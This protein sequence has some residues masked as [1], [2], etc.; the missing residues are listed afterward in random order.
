MPDPTSNPKVDPDLLTSPQTYRVKG[1]KS[2]LVYPDPRLTAEDCEV[3]R[4]M[5][6]T[7]RQ[8]ARKRNGFTLYN[9]TVM[10]SSVAVTG[11]YQLPFK[12]A[13]RQLEMAGT[14]IYADDGTTRTD[15]TD[16]AQTN[17]AEARYRVAFLQ[18]KAICTNGVN[19]PV[20]WDGTVGATEAN[21]L[22]APF[23][24]C[25]DFIVHQNVL[26]ALATTE[27]G[28]KHT[29]RARWCDVDGQ[30]LTVDVTNWP[31]N[32]R[33][34][35]YHDG[36][37]I[38]GG[39]D[40]NGRLLVFKQD[41]MY[42]SVIRV[43]ND[44]Q[45]GQFELF[46]LK[47]SIRRNFEPIAKHSI[48][49]TPEFAWCVARDGAYVIDNA[50]NMRN[51]IVPGIEADW[52]DLNQGRLQ[53][54]VSWIRERDHQVRTLLSSSTNTSG[55]DRVLVWD[56]DTDDVWFD[57]PGQT[58]NYANSF[59]DSN[60]EEDFL[61]STNG[62]VF[63]GNT[64]STDNSEAINWEVKFAPNDIFQ[65]G[66]TKIVT[67]VE[68]LY[69]S[70]VGQQNISMEVIFDQGNQTSF[71]GTLDIASNYTWNSGLKWNT[72]LKWPG[73]AGQKIIFVNRTCETL[74]PRFYGSADFD[75]IG[76]RVHWQVVEN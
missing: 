26:I 1:Q 15:L 29:T 13:T 69:R 28:T 63:K 75:L 16:T 73:G 41:G 8:T 12:S 48:L 17:N 42:P 23:T 2:A 21:D 66:A 68:V 47:E 53:Y 24:A 70:L 22:S 14:K 37:P 51:V 44:I 50:F 4:N 64:G 52:W 56:W 54:A 46:L 33:Y 43:N 32:N 25:D 6:I 20:T 55:H 27:S 7:Q 35:I 38:V 62:Y 58:L 59:I 11:L 5:N 39:V 60:E 40:F 31:T 18:D 9:D 72:G 49:A 45:G 67:N 34:E 19:V 65:Q 36:A 10:A 61:G 74:Q 30:F 3:F 71:S 76:Y 57:T